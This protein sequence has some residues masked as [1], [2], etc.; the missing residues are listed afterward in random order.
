[1]DLVYKGK[2]GDINI[3][4]DRD[5]AR[6]ARQLASDDDILVGKIERVEVIHAVT[7]EEPLETSDRT[8]YRVLNK[9]G[10]YDYIYNSS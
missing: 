5:E 10:F 1:M 8:A 6:L 4:T 9:E 2:N 7:D 3:P